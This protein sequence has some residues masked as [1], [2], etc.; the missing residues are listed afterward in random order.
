MRGRPGTREPT[1]SFPELDS[2]RRPLLGVP[3]EATAPGGNAEPV[4]RA[5][6]P[7]FS[8]TRGSITSPGCEAEDDEEE[9]ACKE[10]E[11]S[12]RPPKT[13]EEEEEKA[14]R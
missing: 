14:E 7:G 13:T 11:N 2:L 5:A 10:Q 6:S 8:P 9:A 1:D 4:A 12:L 3:G